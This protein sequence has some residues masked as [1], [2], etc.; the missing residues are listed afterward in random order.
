MVIIGETISVEQRK[1]MNQEQRMSQRSTRERKNEKEEKQ[2]TKMPKLKNRQKISKKK[3]S[4]ASLAHQAS[5]FQS[6]T[7]TISDC[8]FE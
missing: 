7:Q 8:L 3:S 5:P 2:M 6:F 1:G 4:F